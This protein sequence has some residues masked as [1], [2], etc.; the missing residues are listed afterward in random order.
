MLSYWHN[1]SLRIDD[2]MSVFLSAKFY[3]FVIE[4]RIERQYLCL[5]NFILLSW[6]PGCNFRIFHLQNRFLFH[7][8]FGV[9]SPSVALKHNVWCTALGTKHW[10]ACLYYYIYIFFQETSF[11]GQKATTRKVSSTTVKNMPNKGS[12]QVVMVTQSQS[13]VKH[14]EVPNNELSPWHVTA[15]QQGPEIVTKPQL[16]PIKQE[17]RVH[18]TTE[19]WSSTT[20]TYYCWKIYIIFH[21]LCTQFCDVYINDLCVRL[22]YL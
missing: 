12:A 19:L 4:S 21:K 14:P 1:V 13:N 17:R 10:Q 6:N 7:L 5:Q 16:I 2:G 8:A 9:L 22:Q 15:A 3:P 20:T 18:L 11:A